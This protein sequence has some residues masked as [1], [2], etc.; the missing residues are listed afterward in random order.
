MLVITSSKKFQGAGLQHEAHCSTPI[1]QGPGIGLE[2]TM[3]YI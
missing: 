1:S 2:I 3:Y